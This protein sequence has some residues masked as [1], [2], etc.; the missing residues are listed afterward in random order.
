MGDGAWAG[1]VGGVGRSEDWNMAKVSVRVVGGVGKT[2]KYQLQPFFWPYPPEI[3]TKINSLAFLNFG[4]KSRSREI[5]NRAGTSC[6][7]QYAPHTPAT[8]DAQ[9]LLFPTIGAFP[10]Q[11][12]M[13]KCIL[14][15]QTSH[16][17]CQNTTQVRGHSRG[18]ESHSEPT[19]GSNKNINM[20]NNRGQHNTNFSAPSGCTH[21]DARFSI[22]SSSIS[23]LDH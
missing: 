4:E 7:Q 3:S 17:G 20:P 15:I 10:V 6:R 21:T 22:N 8:V 23:Y 5:T 11:P 16:A 2:I 14:P 9:A 12:G 1:V 18:T 13:R 19:Y